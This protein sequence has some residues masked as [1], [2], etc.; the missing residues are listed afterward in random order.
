MSLTL[1]L[2]LPVATFAANFAAGNQPTLRQGD[3][4]RGNYYVAGGTVLI[5]GT[6]EGDLIV[7][8]GESRYMGISPKTLLSRGA[9]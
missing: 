3:I 6:V 7:A 8:G 5:E 1:L 9:V 4:I 2:V